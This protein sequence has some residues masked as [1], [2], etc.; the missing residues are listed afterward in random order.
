MIALPLLMSDAAS[1]CQVRR[2]ERLGRTHRGELDGRGILLA[3]GRAAQ[4]LL[5]E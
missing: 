2:V 3:G 5:G 1:S 4:L